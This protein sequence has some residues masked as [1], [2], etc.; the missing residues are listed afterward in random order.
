MH[1]EQKKS[2]TKNRISSINLLIKRNW[3]FKLILDIS[4]RI[5]SNSFKR[6]VRGVQVKT[7]SGNLQINNSV[8]FLS[9]LVN[10][11]SKTILLASEFS[12]LHSASLHFILTSQYSKRFDGQKRI[13]CF[14]AISK[15]T[16]NS[17]FELYHASADIMLLI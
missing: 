4:F 14:L 2:Q 16:K 5:M 10:S 8:T 11:C 1:F 13:F 12:L 17:K 3:R 6:F 7:I 15:I 9:F